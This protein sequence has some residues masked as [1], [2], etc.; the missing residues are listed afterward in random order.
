MQTPFQLIEF[1]A[2]GKWSFHRNGLSVELHR[3]GLK[4][5]FDM[6]SHEIQFMLQSARINFISNSPSNTFH[7]VHFTDLTWNWIL[8]FCN[9]TWINLQ[10]MVVLPNRLFVVIPIPSDVF[11]RP[12][13]SLHRRQWWMQ[14]RLFVYYHKVYNLLENTYRDPR[15]GFGQA[16]CESPYLHWYHI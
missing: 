4:M 8:F 11:S 10:L 12:K 3:W 6:I 15:N 9:C 2:R 7:K 14:E 13:I 16:H 1:H 5:Q